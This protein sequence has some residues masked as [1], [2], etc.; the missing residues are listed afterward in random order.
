MVTVLSL[1]L[2][3]RSS[4]SIHHP[5]PSIR[6]GGWTLSVSPST[7]AQPPVRGLSLTTIPSELRKVIFEYAFLGSEILHGISRGDHFGRSSTHCNVLLACKKF[8][9]EGITLCYRHTTLVIDVLSLVT[10]E[11]SI[12][13]KHMEHVQRIRYLELDSFPGS[14]RDQFIRK[15]A[16]LQN[17][18]EIT[19]KDTSMYVKG[20]AKD[21]SNEDIW[22]ASR[23]KDSSTVF[24]ASDLASK[25]PGIKVSFVTDVSLGNRDC[26]QP[27]DTCESVVSYS[28]LCCS[29]RG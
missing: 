19:L 14:A 23:T 22:K 29:I 11:Q 5:N 2:L 25:I 16:C 20:T 3:S 26:L 15:I 27:G 4:I 8:Y 18:H 13:A 9:E 6:D 24:L 17:L 21:V 10:D 7:S 12:S 28:H 1:L